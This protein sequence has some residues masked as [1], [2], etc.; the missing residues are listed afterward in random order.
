[1]VGNYEIEISGSYANDLYSTTSTLQ[2]NGGRFISQTSQTSASIYG[3]SAGYY[4][5][6]GLGFFFSQRGGS[7]SF[8]SFNGYQKE[9]DLTLRL[10]MGGNGF[11][12]EFWLGYRQMN[13]LEMEKYSHKR[14]HKL[15]HHGPPIGNTHRH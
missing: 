8:E 9:Q 1:M 14:E 4:L 2:T 7:L 6:R 12:Q 3:L 5:T 15:F 11:S 13:F 10:R